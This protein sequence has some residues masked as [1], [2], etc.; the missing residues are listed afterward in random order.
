MSGLQNHGPSISPYMPQKFS[1]NGERKLVNSPVPNQIVNQNPATL[2]PLLNGINNLNSSKQ[3]PLTMNLA[4]NAA[5]QPPGLVKSK[6]KTRKR[7]L[8][9]KKKKQ[10]KY[11]NEVRNLLGF[12]KNFPFSNKYFGNAYPKTIPETMYFN[13]IS[14][15]IGGVPKLEIDN[16]SKFLNFRNGSEIWSLS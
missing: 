6:S 4:I 13:P 10:Q 16:Q 9:L 7:K 8:E 14:H 15:D 5:G 2:S 11:K 1:F 12:Q 3:I